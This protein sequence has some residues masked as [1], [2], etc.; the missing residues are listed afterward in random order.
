[1]N[2][3][4]QTLHFIHVDHLNTPRLVAEA[5]GTT[6][7]RWDQVEPFGVNVP[8]QNPSGLGA[9]EFPLR[10]PGQYFDKET[11][12]H[13]DYFRD[14]DPAIGRY[15]QSD[16]IA[17]DGGLNTY[18]YVLASPIMLI[19]PTGLLSCW[20]SISEHTLMCRNNLGEVLATAQSGSG[21]GPCANNP[22]CTARK[23]QG[24][25]PVGYYTIR[26]PGYAPNRPNWLYLDPDSTVALGTG[27]QARGGFFIHPMA[28]TVGCVVLTRKDFSTVSNWARQD[29]GGSLSV[30]Y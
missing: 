18:L 17:L 19:D 22:E 2:S 11:N 15:I 5:T 26:T 14:Y 20:Y 24:P 16:P 27:A 23:D 28:R 4:V 10:F 21:S 7:W 1:M 29:G 9:F 8:D 25:L 6:V 3:A 13:Y 12:L 30:D